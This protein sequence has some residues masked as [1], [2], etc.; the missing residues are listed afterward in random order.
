MKSKE[1]KETNKEREAAKTANAETYVD[2]KLVAGIKRVSNFTSHPT[3]LQFDT[4]V[5]TLIDI[6]L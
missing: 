2:T 5:D 4:S 6:R 1:E 3:A